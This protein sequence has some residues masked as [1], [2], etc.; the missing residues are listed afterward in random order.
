MSRRKASETG[1][2]GANPR[3]RVL[4]AGAGGGGGWLRRLVRWALAAVAVLAALPLVLLALYRAEAVRP[5]STLMVGDWMR[6]RTVAREWVP[7]E[8]ISPNLVHA[9]A[10]SEDARFCA[11]DGVDWGAVS[12]VVDDAL[13]GR[14]A[15]GASTIAMQT[16]KNLFL[17]PG[18]SYLRKA[19]EV[20]LALAADFIL[21]KRRLM[22]IY[23]NIAEWG[24][25]PDG[26]V[27]GAEAAARHHFG[28]SAARVSARQ[29]ALLAATLPNPKAR[30]AGR[31]PR[32]LRRIAARIQARARRSGAYVGCLRP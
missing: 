13:E 19:L 6:G 27:Y 24:R 20:P 8:R 15:R 14:R 7:L 18:R 10:M 11:H 28:R 23:L 9:V 21:G 17:W 29:G 26:A 30:R 4:R 32:G 22:E 25:V 3:L 16:V 31:P 5:V 2:A 1:A 12:T